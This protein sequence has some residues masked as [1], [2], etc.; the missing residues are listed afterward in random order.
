MKGRRRSGFRSKYFLSSSFSP[1]WQGRG[2]VFLLNFLRPQQTSYSFAQ[3]HV[4]FHGAAHPVL[5]G[6]WCLVWHS[7]L[8]V[9]F[10]S[11][12]VAVEAANSIQ[13]V[14]SPNGVGRRQPYAL[15]VWRLKHS[16][17]IRRPD[18]FLSKNPQKSFHSVCADKP[19]D[20]QCKS[21][22]DRLRTDRPPGQLSNRCKKSTPLITITAR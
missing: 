2:T 18:V 4:C 12:S 3:M 11:E 21:V 5:G 7:R 16:C 20:Q 17:V 9:L 6:N 1:K 10:C 13:R 15:R 19:D 14:L 22:S 8:L